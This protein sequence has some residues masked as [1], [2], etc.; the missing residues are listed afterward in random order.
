MLA[1]G[2]EVVSYL[3]QNYFRI[4]IAR[5]GVALA[6]DDDRYLRRQLSPLRLPRSKLA[7]MARLDMQ[8]STPFS[9]QDAYMFY[10][11]SGQTGTA[12]GYAVVKK[13]I[14]QPVL[15]ELSGS[16]I[17]VRALKFL[18]GE[19]AFQPD[20]Q[21]IQQLQPV[22]RIRSFGGRLRTATVGVF[23]LGLAATITHAHWRYYEAGQ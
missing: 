17:A 19:S 20:K 18:G 22:S 10:S 21:S 11:D 6:I 2:A 5:P 13:T 16:G 23:V 8:A 7:A 3:R 12:S 1:N 9:S 4:R 15:D 14:L